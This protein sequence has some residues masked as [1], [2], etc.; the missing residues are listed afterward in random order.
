MLRRS[1]KGLADHIQL[2]VSPQELIYHQRQ[3]L[4]HTITI[5]FPPF[6]I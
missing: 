2:I 3:M 1:W 6:L 4:V 5:T